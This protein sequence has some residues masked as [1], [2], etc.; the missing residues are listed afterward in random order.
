MAPE[1]TRQRNA[2]RFLTNALNPFFVFTALYAAAAFSEAGPPA[3]PGYLILEL[4]AAGLVAGYVLLMRRGVF[5]NAEG[6]LP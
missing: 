3:A 6:S 5:D 2:A 4:L 1:T